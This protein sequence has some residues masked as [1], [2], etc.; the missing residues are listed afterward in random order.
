[1]T[2]PRARVMSELVEPFSVRARLTGEE[3]A[4]RFSHL[5]SAVATRH[6]DTI[7]CKFLVNGRG[8]VVAL[9]HPAMVEFRRRAGRSLSD[10]ETARIAAA[11]LRECLEAD[12]DSQR[13][14]LTVPADEVLRLAEKLGRAH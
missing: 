6:S 4:V 9:A 11:Y 1:M 10:E 5:F 12:R 13:T 14:L 7:D 2:L 3:Y 8:V